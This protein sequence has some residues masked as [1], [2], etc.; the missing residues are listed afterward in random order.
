MSSS[1]RWVFT[2]LALTAC[3]R[4][5]QRTERV[6][7]I[8]E[9]DAGATIALDAVPRDVEVDQYI[10]RLGT[11][12]RE[13]HD[14]LVGHEQRARP[15]LLELLRLPIEEDTRRTMDAM[16]VLAAFGH[17]E[18][19]PLIAARLRGDD[20]HVTFLVAGA[21]ARH[22]AD[23]A[24]DAPSTA[25]ASSEEAVAWASVSSLGVRR[26]ERG[27]EALERALEDTRLRIRLVAVKALMRLGAQ[28]STQ[29]L[30][31]RLDVE[32]DK[33]VQSWIRKALR[34]EELPDSHPGLDDQLE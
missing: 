16:M 31:D 20:P 22:P 1:E 29:A 8:V 30:S 34:G 10:D 33:D 7:A 6:P 14:W 28:P 13:A 19:V 25:A 11:N 17:G 9:V 23:E 21:L 18:D 27:R 15:Y 3:G 32:P 5:P 24:A 4:A 2:L 12:H 26:D